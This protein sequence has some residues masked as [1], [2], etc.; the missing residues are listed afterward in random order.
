MSKRKRNARLKKWYSR[1][2]SSTPPQEILSNIWY[3]QDEVLKKLAIS[4][5]TCYRLRMKGILIA[6]KWKGK[7]YYNE[8]HVQQMLINGLPPGY[9]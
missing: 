4:I 6:S 1:P 3:T 5:S 9:R 7:L 8:Y 2:N